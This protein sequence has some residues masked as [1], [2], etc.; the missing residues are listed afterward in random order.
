M[1]QIAYLKFDKRP[2]GGQKQKFTV[3]LTDERGTVYTATTLQCTR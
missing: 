3:T 1:K 2:D